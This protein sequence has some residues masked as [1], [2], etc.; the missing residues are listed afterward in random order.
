MYILRDMLKEYVIQVGIEM[1]RVINDPNRLLY[2]CKGEGF[3][4]VI[5]AR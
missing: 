5:K 2:M 1:V 4:W 3:H